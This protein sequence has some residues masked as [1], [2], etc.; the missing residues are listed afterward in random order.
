MGLDITHYKATL[1]FQDKDKFIYP[2]V[3]IYG[4]Y[5]YL[6]PKDFED[7]NVDYQHFSNYIQQIQCPQVVITVIQAKKEEYLPEI[8]KHF[9]NNKDYII[10]TPEDE[11]ETLEDE[12]FKNLRCYKDTGALKWDILKFCMLETIEEIYFEAI[13]GQRKGVNNNFWKH[14]ESTSI[15]NFAKHEDFMAAYH[16]IDK[17][18]NSDTDEIVTERKKAFKTSFIDNF[19]E[20]ASFMALCY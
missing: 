17:Y 2:G 18:W 12:R 10:I 4:Q 5:I 3:E 6:T 9:R 1:S 8:K 7:F 16:S 20:G 14:F 19:E 13:G 11:K 15:Y